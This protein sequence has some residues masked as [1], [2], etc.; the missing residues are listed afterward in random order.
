MHTAA[1]HAPAPMPPN[2]VRKLVGT[3]PCP[4]ELDRHGIGPDGALWPRAS[5]EP[6]AFAFADRGRSFAALAFRAGDETRLHLCGEIAPLPY[7]IQSAEI[8]AR[9]LGVMRGLTRLPFGRVRLNERQII[10]VEADLAI[11][12]PATPN[13]L[14]AAAALFVARTRP[15]VD[16]VAAE[17]SLPAKPAARPAAPGAKA[18]RR[19]P[20]GAT[21]RQLTGG[22]AKT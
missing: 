21:G 9:L 10:C 12:G 1:P 4:I 6:L 2:A 8:R 17:A 22:M 11:A 3:L 18:P 19:A 14:I 16:R 20:S 7:T 15:V 5:T 13:R